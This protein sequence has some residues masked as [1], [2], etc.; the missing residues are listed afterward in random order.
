M[1]EGKSIFNHL[2][3][4]SLTVANAL[5]TW[6]KTH[7]V[8]CGGMKLTLPLLGLGSSALALSASDEAWLQVG[9]SFMVA[10]ALAGFKYR[11]DSR[12]HAQ[13]IFHENSLCSAST[14]KQP[15]WKSFGVDWA[16]NA[17][18]G[19]GF[20]AALSF[21]GCEDHAHEHVPR[22]KTCTASI[23]PFIY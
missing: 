6:G 7:L 20:T 15:S 12:Q 11:K 2:G 16:K 22:E 8:C 3:G 14:H 9:G 4:H 18:L 13:Q 23:N 21:M 5:V 17:L 19:L 1:A 10:G